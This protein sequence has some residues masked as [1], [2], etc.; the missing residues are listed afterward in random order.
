MIMKFIQ[1]GE[2]NGNTKVDMIRAAGISNSSYKRWKLP[3]FG[4]RK[5]NYD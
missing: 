2:Q 4:V 3:F 5:Y 1:F